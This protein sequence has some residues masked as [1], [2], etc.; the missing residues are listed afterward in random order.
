MKFSTNDETPPTI[1]DKILKKEI[2]S[3]A[4]YEDELVNFFNWQY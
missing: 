4:V 2:P 1:F 3:K